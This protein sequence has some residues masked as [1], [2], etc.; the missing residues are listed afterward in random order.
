M[1]NYDKSSV[2]CCEDDF[3]GG[4]CEGGNESMHKNIYGRPFVCLIKY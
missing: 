3:V 4:A 2:K 1:R